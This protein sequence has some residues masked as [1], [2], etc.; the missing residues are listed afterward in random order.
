MKKWPNF[1]PPYRFKRHE[2]L[3]SISRDL[4]GFDELIPK[5]LRDLAITDPPYVIGITGEWGIGKS[6]FLEFVKEKAGRYRTL[7]ILNRIELWRF[8]NRV[9]LALIVLEAIAQHFELRAK[10][11]RK[12]KILEKLRKVKKSFLAL[13]SAFKLSIKYPDGTE[14]KT[15]IEAK[16]LEEKLS[17][18][19]KA[20]DKDDEGGFSK[21]FDELVE[22]GL[23]DRSKNAKLVILIDDLDR[24]LPHEAFDLLQKLRVFFNSK[25]V[26]FIIALDVAVV[27]GAIKAQFG[28]DSGIDGHWYLEKLVDRFYDLP[29]PTSEQ[30]KEFVLSRYGDIT[31]FGFNEDA[32]KTI[33]N[34]IFQH[35]ERFYLGTNIE[36]R[37]AMWNPRRL[38][39]ALDRMF[40]T[41]AHTTDQS[42]RYA[43]LSLLVFFVLK[44]AYPEIYELTRWNPGV[45]IDIALLGGRL[46][47]IQSLRNRERAKIEDVISK[48][49]KPVESICNNKTM[50]DICRRLLIMVERYSTTKYQSGP[51]TGSIEE[52]LTD[53]IRRFERLP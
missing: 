7:E 23:S 5:F 41:W 49:G 1:K 10:E 40:S 42:V 22:E 12:R 24:C 44:D 30:L 39:K 19:W 14:V 15:Q 50:I 35:W 16:E 3:E 9:D 20:A 11:E 26:I 4:L 52:K 46:E 17:E 37:S 28:R 31:K 43:S 21:R 47:H 27:S 36:S 38:V 2:P 6:S 34:L 53:C 33:E 32:A 8:S 13:V 48:Y 51:R 45:I 29:R 25:R 18:I